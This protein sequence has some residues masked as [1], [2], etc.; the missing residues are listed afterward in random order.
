ME[1]IYELFK[2]LSDRKRLEILELL[3]ED[4]Q[5]VNDIIIKVGTTQ[6]NV[7]QHLRILKESGIIIVDKRGRNCFI[8]VRNKPQ[9]IKVIYH[10][11]KIMEIEEE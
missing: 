10:A 9:I 1:D 7:S 2:I 11:R 8:I 5:C 6:P 4:E 3:L